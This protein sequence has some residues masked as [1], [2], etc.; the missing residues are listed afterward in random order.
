MKR[1]T[2]I[3]HISG[4][5]RFATTLQRI[6]LN[7]VYKYHVML[8]VV[9][10]SFD[11]TSARSKPTVSQVELVQKESYWPGWEPRDQVSWQRQNSSAIV[12]FAPITFVFIVV[13]DR[14]IIVLLKDKP[15]FPN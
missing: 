1:S 11:N 9:L 3:Q 14:S 5:L 10:V 4:T 2:T 8:F 12:A 7:E 13:N 6:F 15:P